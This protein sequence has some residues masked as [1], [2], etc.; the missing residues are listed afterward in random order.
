MATTQTIPQTTTPFLASDHQDSKKHLLLATTGSVATIKLPQLLSALSK[1]FSPETLTIHLIL[2]PSSKNFLSPA[3][4]CEIGAN[5]LVSRL[6][7]DADE[8][9]FPSGVYTRECPVLHIE[10]RKWADLLV[11]APLSA[12][13]L[14]SVTVGR[15]DGLLLSVLR[16]WDWARA[17][18]VVAPAMNTLM[19]TH[20]VTSGQVETL[21]AWGVEVLMPV[22][23][24]LA[25]GDEGVGGMVGVEVVVETIGGRLR[26]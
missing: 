20:P 19:W 5:P 9:A 1:T 24:V 23:K 12:N 2:S 6:W 17:G 4:L 18:I 15:C 26:I 25:C 10:L 8:W 11:V 21:K 16:A 3:D 13:T 7:S 22:S 14:S